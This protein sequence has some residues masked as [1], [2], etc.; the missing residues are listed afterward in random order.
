MSTRTSSPVPWCSRCAPTPG[1][2]SGN[3]RRRRECRSPRSRERRVAVVHR[4]AGTPWSGAR[5]PAGVPS[6]SVSPT[7]QR[8]RHRGPS[9]L[10]R[11][12]EVVISRRT[13]PCGVSAGRVNGRASTS[14]RAWPIRRSRRTPAPCGPGA[15]C[16]LHNEA[17]GDLVVVADDRLADPAQQRAGRVVPHRP[18]AHDLQRPW[19]AE[20]IRA[21][22]RRCD[23]RT[24]VRS[25][26]VRMASPP[27]PR[28]RR[29]APSARACPAPRRR[30]GART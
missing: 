23:R 9:K 19:Q 30:A 28:A 3:W 10:C 5:G 18:P 14:F 24:G 12:S 11:T 21:F 20:Q 15:E 26:G 22:S 4:R 16:R 6:G 27:Q 1:S 17:D 29:A 13:S 7:P 2:V 8:R 25:G